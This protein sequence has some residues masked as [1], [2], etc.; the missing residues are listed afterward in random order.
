M[1]KPR[2]N[3]IYN[4]NEK[5][6]FGKGYYV[7]FEGVAKEHKGQPMF[8]CFYPIEEKNEQVDVV[9]VGILNRIKRDVINGWV[10]DPYYYVD[11]SQEFKERE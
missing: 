6:G 1:K 5:L 10:Y 11:L 2:V 8:E 7:F 3:F 9:C 4:D